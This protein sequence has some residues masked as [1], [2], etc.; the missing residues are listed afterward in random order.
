MAEEINRCVCCG[1]EITEEQ[2]TFQKLKGIREVVVNNRHGGFS[3]SYE[4][5]LEYLRRAGIVHTLESRGSRD[6]DERYGL[7]IMVDG[8]HWSGRHDINRD[9][10]VL[11]QLVKDW[12]DD[13]NGGFATLA[14]VRIPGN[15]NWLIEEYDGLEW[16]AED[17]RTWYAR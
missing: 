5:E 9:D 16:V 14:I 15:V 6:E 3:L 4:A 2:H 17:H 1:H 13:V 7:K 8:K 10:P 11:V 12:G